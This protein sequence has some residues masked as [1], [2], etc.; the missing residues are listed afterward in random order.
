MNITRFKCQVNC[1]SSRTWDP[2]SSEIPKKLNHRTMP[3]GNQSNTSARRQNLSSTFT[4]SY[5]AS[6]SLLINSHNNFFELSGEELDTDDDDNDFKPA[7][8][9]HK[10]SRP[11]TPPATPPTFNPTPKSS[12]HLSRPQWADPRM[13]RGC[14]PFDSSGKS[15]WRT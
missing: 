3:L 12:Q 6:H 2:L 1:N 4:T 13:P 15:A 7:D 14:G 5:T 8:L 9:D 10:L 11:Y